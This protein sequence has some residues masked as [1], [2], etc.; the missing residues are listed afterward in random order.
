MYKR[1]S[2]GK[3][4][5]RTTEVTSAP[6]C[7]ARS[8]N[9]V[10]NVEKSLIT[11]AVT[12]PGTA[13]HWRIEKFL[14]K[15][16]GYAPPSPI[17]WSE[18]DKTIQERWYNEGVI[19]ERLT[20][21][22]QEGFEGFMQFYR[23]LEFVDDDGERQSG[24]DPIFL[25]RRLWTED[26]EGTGLAIAGTVDLIARVWLKGTIEH[27]GYFHECK[28]IGQYASCQC[29]YQW[30]VTVADWKY[31][32]QKQASHPEQMSSYHWKAA[33]DGVPDK[34]IPSTFDLATNNGEFPINY[35]NW[36]VLLKK[37]NNR[38]GYTLHKYPQ[39]TTAFL[40]A[41]KII[42][43]PKFRTLSHR[44]MSYGLKGVCMFCQYP[45]NCPD[46]ATTTESTLVPLRLEERE[47]IPQQIS[48]QPVQPETR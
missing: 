22:V 25:E 10:H 37:P 35:E 11:N 34:R 47:S 17:V 33:N 26:F 32:I 44:T 6:D 3:L 13:M 41:C 19:R 8:Y 4:F 1:E 40:R 38:I 39:D 9:V 30:T 12:M 7:E 14:R 36:S 31:S 15:E 45:N 46:R 43:N 28:H 29:E 24:L 2:D 27:D 16:K 21:P 48:F 42:M 18:G 23:S 20:I 5:Y